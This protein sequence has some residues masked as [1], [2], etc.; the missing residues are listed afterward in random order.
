L[1]FGNVEWLNQDSIFSSVHRGFLNIGGFDSNN[2][3]PYDGRV[4]N[5]R[6]DFPQVFGKS[7]VFAR[8]SGDKNDTFGP[9]SGNSLPSN[10]R[11]NANRDHNAQAGL[12]TTWAKTVND[13][14]FNFQRIRND[15]ILPTEADCPPSNA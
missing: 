12:T 9:V 11:V 3:S 7:R 4:A 2:A 8:Y 10:W 14:R 15:S 13:F 1:F 5:V 6:V